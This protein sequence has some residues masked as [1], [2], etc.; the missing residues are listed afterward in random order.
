MTNDAGGK[1]TDKSKLT[2]REE[3]ILTS[4]KKVLAHDDGNDFAML[5]SWR[6]EVMQAIDGESDAK[7]MA[8]NRCKEKLLKLDFIVE[9]D[10][11]IWLCEQ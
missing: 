8:F 9:R 10:A 5:E 11:Q 7:R 3:V 1:T 2:P 6:D 4:L